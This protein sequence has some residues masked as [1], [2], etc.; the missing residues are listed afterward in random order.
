ML[1]A[2]IPEGLEPDITKTKKVLNEWI[3]KNQPGLLKSLLLGL[4]SEKG[5]RMYLRSSREVEDL[6]GKVSNSFHE[7]FQKTQ[8]EANRLA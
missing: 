1:P 5:F 2:P 4:D 7:L 3:E 6:I 8:M